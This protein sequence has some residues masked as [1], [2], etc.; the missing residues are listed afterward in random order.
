MREQIIPFQLQKKLE[1]LSAQAEHPFLFVETGEDARAIALERSRQVCLGAHESPMA[2]RPA[3][4]FLL[5]STYLQTIQEDVDHDLFSCLCGEQSA[6]DD[7][8]VLSQGTPIL[9]TTPQ[10]AIDQLRRDTLSLS[11]TKALII[12]YAFT[13]DPQQAEDEQ[14][15]HQ[16][17]FL[18]DIRFICTK[19]GSD[20]VIECYVDDL[21]LLARQPHQLSEQHLVLTQS[22][23]IYP[24][25]PIE[26]YIVPS[27]AA[28][29]ILAVL[30][31]LHQSPYLIIHR[32]E[33]TVRTLEQRLRTAVPPLT[34]ISITSD[35]LSVLE[36]KSGNSAFHTVATVGLNS[37]GIVTMLRRLHAKQCANLHIVCMVTPTQAKEIITSKETMLMNKEVKPLP[38]SHEVIA[39]KIQMFVGKAKV[40]P[41]PEELES[42][43]KL[44][45]KNVPLPFR[46]YFAAYLLREIIG[47]SPSANQ[48]ARQPSPAPSQTTDTLKKPQKEEKTKT[49]TQQKKPSIPEGART[50][51]LNIGK[52]RRLSGKELSQILQEE[53][54]IPNEEIYSIRIHDKYS[55]ITLPAQRAEEV[56]AKLN[57]KEIKGHIVSVNYSNKG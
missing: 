55:F 36:Q 16:L 37:R 41:N 46:G 7:L 48:K 12:A 28:A 15:A 10:L 49:T 5:D 50:L 30:Y 9:A 22:D 54:G 32:D 38:E 40:D 24:G 35:Q 53:V 25:I 20:T 19:L 34:C 8:A 14:N 33:K 13:E 17:A 4:L 2:S 1:S 51:H 57:G 47:K 44:I 18:D 3:V 6:R 56:I 43:R 39:G 26:V 27:Y 45:K 21:S 52:M 29:H 11:D 42:L 23:W 31:A